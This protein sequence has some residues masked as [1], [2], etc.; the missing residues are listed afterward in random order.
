METLVL[1]TLLMFLLIL[2]CGF[3]LF[4]HWHFPR[5]HCQS[6]Q[7][8]YFQKQWRPSPSNNREVT[9]Y[10]TLSLSLLYGNKWAILNVFPTPWNKESTS[11][12]DINIWRNWPVFLT[13]VVGFL[14][15]WVVMM[16]S[17]RRYHTAPLYIVR[18]SPDSIGAQDKILDYTLPPPICTHNPEL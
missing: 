14:V 10:V 6:S 17:E 12:C 18:T 3:T 13:L 7:N 9:M 2:L 11:L 4:S 16:T 1:L 5:C 15:V 8:S